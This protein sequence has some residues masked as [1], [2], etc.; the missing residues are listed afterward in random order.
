[1]PW[2][3]RPLGRQRY[4][5][6]RQ[7]TSAEKPFEYVPHNED[8]KRKLNYDDVCKVQQVPI[9]SCTKGCNPNVVVWPV[10]NTDHTQLKPKRQTLI[11]GR[12]PNV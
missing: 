3:D 2:R 5:T 4:G 11:E 9:T 1:M 6:W 8:N 12:S 10:F 7:G